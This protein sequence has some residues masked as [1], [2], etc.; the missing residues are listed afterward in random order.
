MKVNNRSLV[1]ITI[2]IAM[3]FLLA[4]CEMKQSGLYQI[5]LE[6]QADD[7]SYVAD[8]KTNPIT[9][10]QTQQQTQLQSQVQAQP[11]TIFVHVCGEV[12]NPGVYELDE[13]SRVFEAIESAG[14]F[15]DNAYQDYVNLAAALNDGAKIIIP[16]V[17]DA[18]KLSDSVDSM[19]EYVQVNVSEDN[20]TLV[21]I[22]TA[23]ATT[24]CSIS[25]IGATK[26][27]AIVDYRNANGDFGSTEE[28]MNV[29]GIG[30]GTYS[31]IKDKITVGQ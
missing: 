10:I 11:Q 30:E 16:S 28:I 15:T 29:T 23:D 17:D 13:G 3:T 22:N 9:Q 31:K 19:S 26:A 12:N 14:G 18:D 4:G 2:I 1:Y 7:D 21:N 6:E 25:G 5:N 27:D 24:L 8:E 20:S